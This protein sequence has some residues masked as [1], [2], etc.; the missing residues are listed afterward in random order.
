MGK[1]KDKIKKRRLLRKRKHDDTHDHET[2]MSQITVT[3][4]GNY[5]EDG[6]FGNNEDMIPEGA[7]TGEPL[8]VITARGNAEAARRGA[9]YFNNAMGR[10]GSVISP[11]AL[12]FMPLIGGPI[13]MF[14][15]ARYLSDQTGLTEYA[16]RSFDA[17][18]NTWKNAD[19]KGVDLQQGWLTVPNQV[20]NIVENIASTDHKALVAADEAGSTTPF[21]Y[22]LRRDMA[23]SDKNGDT[24]W[25]PVAE[26]AGQ[27]L[28]FFMPAVASFGNRGFYLRDQGRLLTYKPNTTTPVK[29]GPL[30]KKYSPYPFMPETF[31]QAG[32]PQPPKLKHIARKTRHD[33]LKTIRTQNNYQRKV[34]AQISDNIAHNP[35]TEEYHKLVYGKLFKPETMDVPDVSQNGIVVSPN[36]IDGSVPVDANV[37]LTTPARKAQLL[38]GASVVGDYAIGANGEKM[39]V[40]TLDGTGPESHALYAFYDPKQYYWY[41]NSILGKYINKHNSDV[42][43]NGFAASD[44]DFDDYDNSGYDTYDK[45]IPMDIEELFDKY[46]QDNTLR[47]QYVKS[48]FLYGTKGIDKYIAQQL[49]GD[50]DLLSITDK[51]QTML[52]GK[53]FGKWHVDYR[54]PGYK[55]MLEGLGFDPNTSDRVGTGLYLRSRMALGNPIRQIKINDQLIAPGFIENAVGTNVTGNSFFGFQH[56]PGNTLIGADRGG[57]SGSVLSVAPLPPNKIS[58]IDMIAD[59]LQN[60]LKT[61]ANGNLHGFGVD[62]GQEHMKKFAEFSHQMSEAKTQYEM[63]AVTNRAHAYALRNN[64][65]GYIGQEYYHD[66]DSGESPLFFGK[67]VKGGYGQPLVVART[68]GTAGYPTLASGTLPI[69]V[70]GMNGM[71]VTSGAQY[72]DVETVKRQMDSYREKAKEDWEGDP[73]KWRRTVGY[74]PGQGLRPTLAVDTP[75]EDYSKVLKYRSEYLPV[76]SRDIL[77]YNGVGVSHIYTDQ[78]PDANKYLFGVQDLSDLG[79]QYLSPKFDLRTGP[80][81]TYENFAKYVGWMR[82]RGRKDLKLDFKSFVEYLKYINARESP[83]PDYTKMKYIEQW[84]PGDDTMYGVPAIITKRQEK[85]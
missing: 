5:V 16:K 55:R 58:D 39:K 45:P 11:L 6:N 25:G 4:D 56:T 21:M 34:L 8:D 84:T 32:L 29:F 17:Y 76:G 52:T 80:L 7:E 83:E 37:T 19:I 51:K 44:Y 43:T 53:P 85:K 79:N 60:R 35:F 69:K 77:Y 81:G 40:V 2:D 36:V 73:Y 75:L 22:G 23:L 66:Q 49:N 57:V 30:S 78:N 54:S 27:S 64:L 42:V 13:G 82:A 61:D 59:L 15:T 10:A 14:N 70:N 68:L 72:I 74:K 47:D 38:A 71:P 46:M 28:A 65:L 33:V 50:P 31:S 18:S 20:A 1:I 26:L 3:P 24:K 67:M 63:D 48:R 12:N 41:T 9:K 62:I